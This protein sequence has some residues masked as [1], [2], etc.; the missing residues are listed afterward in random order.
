MPLYNNTD[1]INGKIM[2]TG[3][4]EAMMIKTDWWDT[5]G[6]FSS[7]L[8]MSDLVRCVSFSMFGGDVDVSLMD[9]DEACDVRAF[10]KF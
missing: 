10:Y 8:S 1:L 6:Y 3:V 7:T 2:A 4:P 9:Q 5:N